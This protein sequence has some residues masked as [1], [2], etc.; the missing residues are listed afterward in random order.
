MSSPAPRQ[1]PWPRGDLALLVAALLLGAAYFVRLGVVDVTEPDEVRYAVVGRTMVESG[2][3]IT[4]RVNGFVY[5]DKPPLL[6]WLNAL[7]MR[8]SGFTAFA[9]RLP[10][11]LAGLGTVA[12]AAG[13]AAGLAGRRAG[14]WTAIVLL[15]AVLPA[16]VSRLCRY[17]AVFTLG[18]TAALACAWQ[19]L[20]QPQRLG[21]YIGAGAGVAAAILTKGPV[22]L[23]LVGGP[24]FA[25]WAAAWWAGRRSRVGAVSAGSPRSSGTLTWPYWLAA[26]AVALLLAA[27]WFVLTEALHPGYFHWFI[28]NEHLARVHG[29]TGGQH[30]QPFWYLLPITL[31]GIAPWSLLLL[32]A[33]PAATWRARFGAGGPRADLFLLCWAATPVVFF[34]LAQGKLP[35]YVLPALPPLAVLI[36]CY[37][38]GAAGGVPAGARPWLVAT[39]IVCLV[40]AVGG[41]AASV[42]RPSDLL[43]TVAPQVIAAAALLALCGLVALVASLLRRPVPALLALAALGLGEVLTIFE[44]MPAFP[45]TE[46]PEAARVAQRLAREGDLLI[47]YDVYN[48]ALLWALGG[49]MVVVGEF[50]NEYEYPENAGGLATWYYAPDFAGRAFLTTQ[51]IVCIAP[52]RDVAWLRLHLQDRIIQERLVRTK[53]VL[54]VRGLP[55]GPRALLDPAP[56]SAGAPPRETN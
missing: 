18:L 22:A 12:V 16:G 37:L 23:V 8:L 5:L 45:V 46:G 56:G 29:A 34:S 2:D 48:G 35:P 7:S 47:S 49:R 42:R 36:G 26:L 44:A 6:H 39:G 38:A 43:S 13:L 10:S 19:A 1:Q 15:S 20:R 40:L 55:P 33:F 17:D 14:L 25:Y 53:V 54:V 11:V 28:T 30:A 27:P 9:A 41:A 32:P 50:P 52:E 4:P 51:R 24:V 31:V 21:W 3:A